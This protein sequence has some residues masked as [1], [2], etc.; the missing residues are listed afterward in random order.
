M[1][2]IFSLSLLLMGFFL[3]ILT[4]DAKVPGQMSDSIV[5]EQKVIES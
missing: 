3:S 4:G 2:G 5:F 1:F